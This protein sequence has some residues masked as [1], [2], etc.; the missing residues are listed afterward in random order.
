MD[1]R[2]NCDVGLMSTRE[3][4][5]KPSSQDDGTSVDFPNIAAELVALAKK[6]ETECNCP[7]PCAVEFRFR[8]SSVKYE[9]LWVLTQEG[10]KV[11]TKINSN[12]N[13]LLEKGKI[14][15]APAVSL[16]DS[17]YKEML[18]SSLKRS[19][20]W[21]IGSDG[22]SLST[23]ENE[24]VSAQWA[25]STQVNN[26]GEWRYYSDSN[27]HSQ[28]EQCLS[29]KDVV[30]LQSD[31]LEGTDT[32]Y[33]AVVV[34]ESAQGKSKE[35]V[36][37]YLVW[38]A[39]NS[40][41]D[42]CTKLKIELA[43]VDFLVFTSVRHLLPRHERARRHWCKA[44]DLASKLFNSVQHCELHN[45]EN[46]G[47]K[48]YT[49]NKDTLD[50]IAFELTQCLGFISEQ[51]SNCFKSQLDQYSRDSNFQFFVW[52]GKALSRSTP[53]CVHPSLLC[54]ALPRRHAS[55]GACPSLPTELLDKVV[56]VPLLEGHSGN[57]PAC[58]PVLLLWCL[59]KIAPERGSVFWSESRRVFLLRLAFLVS[60]DSS[61]EDFSSA[62]L[63]ANNPL[64]WE[65]LNGGE[66]SR[67]TTAHFSRIRTY[68]RH[69]AIALESNNHD[70]DTE[71]YISVD[72]GFA[73]EKPTAKSGI[74]EPR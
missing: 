37:A 72:F 52:L 20:L 48:E 67:Q 68:A 43:V 18:S 11:L 31:V 56:R 19:R 73:C 53:P 70:S 50:R 69:V 62:L 22:L 3:T 21:F 51:A 42:E 2:F 74:P 32:Q 25:S 23:S 49:S 35:I 5:H 16:I 33:L 66:Y 40:A 57:D 1:A 44:H 36:A 54:C 38:H 61:P 59:T 10:A 46:W 65:E 30:P 26:G 71:T 17:M 63:K 4:V 45:P 60:A 6:V 64:Q 9:K 34:P 14:S 24:T 8:S 15:S 29:L 12:T 13:K 28:V 41:F 55:G 39:A 58:D 47:A 27:V 7:C